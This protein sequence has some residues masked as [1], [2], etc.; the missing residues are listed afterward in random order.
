MTVAFDVAIERTLS[1]EGGYVDNPRDPGGETQWG[2]SKRSYPNVDI[3]NLTRDDAKKIYFDDF[4]TPCGQSLDDGVQFQVFDAA[5]NHGIQTAIRM[6]QRAVGA[7][8]DG[9]WGPF[10]QSAYEKMTEADVIL[11][12]LAERLEFMAKLNRF[13]DFGRG[14]SRRIAQNLRYGAQDS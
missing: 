13:T 2:I 9:H 10:S 7:A 3:K 14:W 12:F 1:H 5:V 11:L 6:L 8:D 4:W